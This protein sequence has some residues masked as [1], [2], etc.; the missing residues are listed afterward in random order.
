MDEIRQGIQERIR[1]ITHYSLLPHSDIYPSNQ[2]RRSTSVVGEN[3]AWLRKLVEQR[4]PLP[5]GMR[6]VK[7]S[8]Y[9][10]SQQGDWVWRGNRVFD[11]RARHAEVSKSASLGVSPRACVGR[12]ACVIA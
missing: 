9:I 11:L 6:S 10:N 1:L 5:L 4:I 7:S 3:S 2:S 12:S 8:P